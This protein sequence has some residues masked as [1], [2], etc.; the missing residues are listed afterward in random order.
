MNMS[1]GP[2]RPR[3]SSGASRRHFLATAVLGASLGAGARAQSSAGPRPRLIEDPFTLGV[4]SGYPHPGGMVLWTRLAPRPAQPGG[5]MPQVPVQI[6]YLVATDEALNEVVQRGQ[7]WAEPA[8][9][10]SVHVELQ[11]LQPNRWYRYRFD[12]DGWHSSVGRT[13][14]TPAASADAAGLRLRLA[15]AACQHYE[16]GY[17]AAYRQMVADRPDLIVHLGDYIYEGSAGAGAT[18]NIPEGVPYALDDYRI[19]HARYKLDPDLQRAHASCPWLV[20]WDDHEV[21]NDYA[22]DRSQNNDPPQWFLERRAAAYRAYYE[23]MPLPRRMVPMGPHARLYDEVWYGSLARLFMLDGRQFRTPQACNAPGRGGGAAVDP[24]RCA[25]LLDPARSFFGAPQRDWL[26]SRMPA[27]TQIPWNLFGQQTLFQPALIHS[28]GKPWIHTE[29]WDGYPAERQALLDAMADP[30]TRNPVVLS[31]DVHAFYANALKQRDDDPASKSVATEFVCGALTSSTPAPW[32]VE[33]VQRE[34]AAVKYVHTARRGYLRIELT[35]E[36]LV[37]DVMGVVDVRR[38]D[39]PT[40]SIA[41]L[42]VHADRPGP[43][44]LR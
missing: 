38:A 39:S 23:H 44:V 16:V 8:W 29:G 11:G 42:V 17:F 10:H 9:A 19:R 31:G 41:S 26:L 15:V 22:G 20:T 14:T 2:M 21:E 7:V 18:R 13:R 4:A 24:A 34:H 25:A 35:S 6:N 28:R 36:R 3:R 33:Q 30:R 32:Y 37:A 27:A 5:G 40:E 43:I 12:I 1:D